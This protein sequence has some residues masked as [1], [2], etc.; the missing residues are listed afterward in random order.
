MKLAILRMTEARLAVRFC[1]MHRRPT[2]Q[3]MKLAV[4]AQPELPARRVFD[5]VLTTILVL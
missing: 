4:P 3:I 5:A 2:F 1:S